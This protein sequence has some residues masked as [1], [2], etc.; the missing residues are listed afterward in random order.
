MML[1]SNV[2]LSLAVTIRIWAGLAAGAIV[3]LLAVAQPAGAQA[4]GPAKA[5]ASV[6]PKQ[7]VTPYNESYKYSV[8]LTVGISVTVHLIDRARVPV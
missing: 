7:P 6:G 3:T 8:D 1:L 2:S 5:L 4:V